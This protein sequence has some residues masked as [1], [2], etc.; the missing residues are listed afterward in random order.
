[1]D[2][3]A[4]RGGIKPANAPSAEFAHAPSL[5]RVV[6]N[7]LAG[8]QAA[9]AEGGAAARR[10]RPDII[11]FGAARDRSTESLA[12]LASLIKP[13]EVVVQVETEAPALPPGLVGIRSGD[14]VQMVLTDAPVAVADARI[15]MLGEADA[16]EMLALAQLTE[17]GPFTLKARA[18]GTF[19]GI[20]TGGRLVAMAGERTKIDGH[21]EVSG[22]CSH[23]D[24][25]GR[26][27]ARLLSIFVT[28]RI[29]DRGETPYLHGWADNAAAIRLYETI[30]FTV[31]AEL[32][33][34]AAMKA[35]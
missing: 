29:L 1:V 10:Y 11:P 31:R 17:P 14:L 2:G 32:K 33:L 23:P 7:G 21:S 16:A 5:D 6:W 4:R 35:G 15:E 34:L 25:R 24:F 18:L 27:L 8:R 26:G 30:G 3:I 20:R 22:V 28:R 13:G 12:A 19:Y 9:F